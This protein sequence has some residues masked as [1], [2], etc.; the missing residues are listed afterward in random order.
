MARDDD[1]CRVDFLAQYQVAPAETLDLADRNKSVHA[2]HAVSNQLDL[3]MYAGI[4]YPS[5]RLATAT[6]YV[7]HSPGDHV[8][9]AQ[10]PANPVRTHT[11]VI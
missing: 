7:L 4:E 5:V 9:F 10:S 11:P 3:A 8:D 6:N 2:S 1:A